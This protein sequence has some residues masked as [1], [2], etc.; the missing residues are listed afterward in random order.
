MPAPA[1]VGRDANDLLSAVCDEEVQ[2]RAF[3]A[4]ADGY[5]TKP[6]RPRELVGRLLANLRRVEPGGEKPCV[7]LGGL[8][9]TSRHVQCAAT[10]RRSTSH[11]SS[12]SFSG[13]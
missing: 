7:E 4:G 6:F 3:E 11:R 12:S 9:M 2:V 8:E 13:S 10:V 1:R 5:V